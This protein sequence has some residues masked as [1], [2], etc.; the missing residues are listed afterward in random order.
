MVNPN[1]LKERPVNDATDDFETSSSDYTSKVAVPGNKTL[2]DNTKLK[3]E[4]TGVRSS[5][6]N[7]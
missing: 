7:A 2:L 6:L 1:H 3:S 4:I 5:S